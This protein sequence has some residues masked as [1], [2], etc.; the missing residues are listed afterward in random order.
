VP[1]GTSLVWAWILL[2]CLFGTTYWVINLVAESPRLRVRPYLDVILF[3]SSA[4]LVAVVVY[5]ILSRLIGVARSEVSW[6]DAWDSILAGMSTP[7]GWIGLLYIAVVTVV[8]SVLR[9]MS[10]MVG[11][12]VLIN[13][14]LGK[15]HHPKS[16][17][18]IF[19]F[20]DLEGS[21]GHAERLGHERFCR[22]IQECFRDLTNSAIQN[23]VEIYQ[24]VGDEA[25]LTWFPS[26]GL[27]NCHCVRVYFDFQS[28]LRARA[29]Y[30]RET[31]GV[32]PRFKAGVNLGSV[33]VAEVG[34]L[35]RDIA[36]LSD[37]L[38]TAARL[39]ALCKEYLADLLITGQVK[40]NLP[41]AKD[42]EYELVG[43]LT[44]R[45]KSETVDVFRA[46]SVGAITDDNERGTSTSG[47]V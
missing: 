22:L 36:Y 41:Q 29:D 9:Q 34:V 16:E 1:T 40:E 43:K 2:G 20:L 11:P 35:K 37:V 13:L 4:M 26:E 24:Y 6:A 19:M 23:R 44:L 5:Y 3:K 33:T 38:N 14:L 32:V 21:T 8:F 17:E 42:L 15:Y 31:F 18:R 25:I 39:E 28:A 10:I 12:R 47:N 45:G 27:R 46:T 7:V 30:Y